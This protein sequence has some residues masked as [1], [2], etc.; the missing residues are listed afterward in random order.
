MTWFY[1]ILRTSLL[2]HGERTLYSLVLSILSF[3]L[4]E[5]DVGMHKGYWCLIGDQK[6]SYFEEKQ[7]P[8]PEKCMVV[9]SL[10]NVH[11]FSYIKTVH[12]NLKMAGTSGYVPNLSPWHLAFGTSAE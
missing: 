12:V 6:G 10:A 9:S 4:G 1:N 8:S 7:I 2:I 3:C 5:N 11:N